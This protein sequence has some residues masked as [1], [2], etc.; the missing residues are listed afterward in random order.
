[1]PV[2]ALG[3]A[4]TARSLGVMWNNYEQSLGV[5]PYL[6]R[7]FFGTDKKIGLK[8]SFIKGRNGLPVALKGANFDA[9]APLRNAI[10]FSTIENEMPFFRESYMVSE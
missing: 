9:K 1:M 5:A 2:L 7:S 4:F 6:G 3:N 8:M 10:G